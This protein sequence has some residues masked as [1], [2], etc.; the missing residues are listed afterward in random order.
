VTLRRPR[1][2]LDFV[3]QITV[4]APDDQSAWW[5]YRFLL[6]AVTDDADIPIEEKLRLLRQEVGRLNELVEVELECNEDDP[7]NVAAAGNGENVKWALVMLA[8][9]LTLRIELGESEAASSSQRVKEVYHSLIEIDADHQRYYQS[10][11][12]SLGME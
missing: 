7:S 12:R 6:A 10:R 11:L 2:E 4:T 8:H 5:Y 9:V 3:Q 1:Q